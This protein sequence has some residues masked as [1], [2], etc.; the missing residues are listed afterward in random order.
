[1]KKTIIIIMI[2]TIILIAGCSQKEALPSKDKDA[3]GSINNCESFCK[4]QP[5]IMCVGYWNI[6][7]IYPDC[8]CGFVC[9]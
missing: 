4:T 5:H 1:M 2:L 3:K 8:N 7:G 9:D 6:S